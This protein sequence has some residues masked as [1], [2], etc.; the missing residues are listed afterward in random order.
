MKRFS[1]DHLVNT[2]ETYFY[3]SWEIDISKSKFNTEYSFGKLLKQNP[4]R[5]IMIVEAIS[6]YLACELLFYFVEHDA[7][8]RRGG[9]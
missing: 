7:S 9:T 8:S 3:V 4:I 5:E 6:N 1:N 2:C